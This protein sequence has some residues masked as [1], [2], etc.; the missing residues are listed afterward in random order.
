MTTKDKKE[1]EKLKG[2]RITDVTDVPTFYFGNLATLYLKCPW[3]LVHNNERIIIG[4]TEFKGQSTRE[5]GMHI[6]KNE[7]LNKK[8]ISFEVSEGL[9]DIRIL[10]EGKLRLDV[11]VHSALYESWN[12]FMNQR[13][14]IAIAGGQVAVV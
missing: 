4:D 1:L 12:L 3:R 11:F 10:L 6:L 5:K 8:I 9:K 13:N 2:I 7:I 14:F